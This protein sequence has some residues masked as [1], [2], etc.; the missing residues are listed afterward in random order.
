VVLWLALTLWLAHEYL[1]LNHVIHGHS[2][3]RFLHTRHLFLNGEKLDPAAGGML[4][5]R[6]GWT[7][8]IILLL[9]NF[10]VL[11]KRWSPLKKY[12][13]V[14]G[15]L[16][17]HIFCGMIGPTFIVF[18]TN[19]KVGGL[20]A[21]SFWSMIVSF[22][23]GV[24]GRYFYLQLLEQ[25]GDLHDRIVRYEDSFRR[26]QRTMQ[27]PPEKLERM[28]VESLRLAGGTAAMAAG[29]ASL[30]SVVLDSMA[31]DL[32]LFFQTPTV[33]RGLPRALGV[34]LRDY[35][36]A[37]RRLIT[38]SYYHRL[39][40]YWHTFHVPFAVFMYSVSIIH[41]AAALIFRVNY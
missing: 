32:R 1:I 17:F 11:R 30:L 6:L 18:H 35:G 9:T 7:G 26:L 4:S 20:V 34:H 29:R 39:M 38:A 31:G 16:N 24:V 40:G 3:L 15:W 37:R 22:T 21:I 23:S 27:L 36:R 14:P 19:F 25:A 28:K 8:F 33:P 41:I 10:Y 12:G 2:V 5:Y 13:S